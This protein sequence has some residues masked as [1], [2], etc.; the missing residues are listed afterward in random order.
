[1]TIRY[2]MPYDDASGYT[3]WSKIP[4]IEPRL[5]AL[6]AHCARQYPEHEFIVQDDDRMTYGQAIERSSILARHML[7]AGVGKG[8][9]VGILFPNGTEFL[10]AWLAVARI[11]AV[12]VPI[13]TLSKG[14]EILRTA[15]HADL[16]LIISTDGYLTNDYIERMESSFPGLTSQRGRLALTAAPFLRAVWIWG[17]NV[18]AWATAVDLSKAPEFDDSFLAAIESEVAPSDLIS[19]IYTS[20]STADPKGVMHSH[21]AFLRQGAKMAA[22]YPYHGDDRIFAPMPFFWVG[23]LTLTLLNVMHTGG[24][25]LGSVKTGSALLDFLERERMTYMVSW[26]H[27]ARAV[28]ADPSFASRDFSSMRGG[29]LVEALPE[30]L[31]PKNQLFFGNALGMSESSANHTISH[32]DFPDHLRGS[33]GMPMPGMQHR[34]LDVDTGQDAEPGATGELAIRGDALMVGMVKRDRWDVFDADGWYRTGDLCSFREGHLFFHGRLDDMIKTSGANV[35][36]REVE[37]VLMSLP[38]V[39]QANVSSIPDAARGAVVGA[40]VVPKPGETLDPARLRDGAADVLSAYKVPRVIVI[41]EAAKLPM[42]S[43]S[44]VDRRALLKILAQAHEAAG[45]Q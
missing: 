35:S 34:I 27:M 23:G 39:A 43:S 17:R 21:S 9:R 30:A 16:H 24:K 25:V 36:P 11:G 22:T 32:L 18:P 42:M 44:K 31:R 26:P 20:G 6:I 40:I 12:V 33:M 41:M 8:T 15:R 45:K 7:A 14:A 28:A 2:G 38:G 19:I 13:S 3:D 29:S 37:A 10:V 4:D 5:P 1:M